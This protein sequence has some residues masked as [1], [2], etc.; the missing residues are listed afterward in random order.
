MA[1]IYFIDIL[2]GGVALF[3]IGSDKWPSFFI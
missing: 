1:Q 3:F 2:Q